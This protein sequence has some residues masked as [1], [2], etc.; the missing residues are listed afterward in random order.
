VRDLFL[1]ERSTVELRAVSGRLR[2]AS[3]RLRTAFSRT[4]FKA[5]VDKFW[6]HQTVKFDFTADLTGLELK[7]E[8]KSQSD[9]VLLMIVDN[10]DTDLE[11]TPASVILC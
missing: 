1:S 6:Q 2:A 10:N 8:Q 5:Q 7:T 11:V 3:G 9:I 4:A